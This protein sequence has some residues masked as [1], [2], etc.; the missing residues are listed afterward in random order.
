MASNERTGLLSRRK[1]D[2]K[3]H[4]FD[5]MEYRSQFHKAGRSASIG[6]LGGSSSLGT[7]TVSGKTISFQ[8]VT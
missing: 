2:D 8:K 3:E 1:K 5:A 4:A 6:A 7:F